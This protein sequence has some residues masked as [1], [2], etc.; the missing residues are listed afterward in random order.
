MKLINQNQSME[1]TEDEVRYLIARMPQ[2]YDGCI[3]KEDF[4]YREDLYHDDRG[5]QRVQG[6]RDF[7]IPSMREITD[8]GKWGYDTTCK[9]ARKLQQFLMKK[10]HVDSDEAKTISSMMQLDITNNCEMQDI[11]NLL[12][13]F[14]IFLDSESHIQGMIDCINDLWN[15]TRMLVNR[16]FTPNEV[17]R[18][19]RNS[20][21]VKSDPSNIINFEQA[22]K[23]KVY[24]NDPCPCGSG[25]KYKNCCKMKK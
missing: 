15:H 23:N 24:P 10:M 2:E 7:Y 16:G 12:E 6:D 3:I 9:Y 14:G 21:C 17:M 8:Y 1:L 19:E 11:F 22:R 4:I 18:I 5:L 20:L 25:K 13:E